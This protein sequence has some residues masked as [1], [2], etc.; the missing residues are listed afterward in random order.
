VL[1]TD[2]A[3]IGAGPSGSACAGLLAER[4][5]DVTLIDQHVFPRDKACGDGLLPATTQTLRRIGLA[6]LL[7]EGL[8][9]NGSRLIVGH[10][11]ERLKRFT[12]VRAA[13]IRRTSLDKALLDHAIA[14]GVTFIKA[15]ALGLDATGSSVRLTNGDNADLIGARRIVA[16]DGPTSVMRRSAGLGTP[17]YAVRAWALRGYFSTERPLDGLF[18]IYLPLEV[19]GMA[20][21]G[22]G[23]LF[24]VDLHVANVGVVFL[25][26]RGAARMP[27]LSEALDAFV[28]ELRL[29]ASHRYGDIESCGRRA[30]SP[31]GMNFNSARC[32]AGD[33]LL[34]GDAAGVTN[35]L[36]GEGIGPALESAISGARWIER[37][38]KGEAKLLGHGRELGRLMPGAGQ[39][40]SCVGRL[41][42][43]RSLT[44]AERAS[45]S[46][47][48]LFLRSVARMALE[49]KRPDPHRTEV[50]TSLRGVDVSIDNMLASCGDAVLDAIR[51]PFPF[52]TQMLA[53]HWHAMG[54][55]VASATFACALRPTSS[56]AADPVS[57][58]AVAFEC[59]APLA[60][61]IG[62]LGDGVT[63]SLAKLNNAF[64]ILTA[65]FA[66]S[67]ALDAA[68]RV[69]P[70]VTVRFFQ[71]VRDICQ[72]GAIDAADR[73]D[74]DRP[75]RRVIMA[76][77]LKTGAV[78][79]FAAALGAEI[80]DQ[81]S[82]SVE[83]LS[84]F[85]RHLGVA[86][87][88]AETVA[89]LAAIKET[90]RDVAAAIGQGIYSLP[91][92]YAIREDAALRKSL[93]CGA[94]PNEIV[95]LV[96]RLRDTGSIE[97]VRALI[98][99]RVDAALAA[100]APLDDLPGANLL[101][102]TD[103]VASRA[104]YP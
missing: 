89:E 91:F 25:R 17:G 23:W 87:S 62:C 3:V 92:L 52:T 54:G 56:F 16:S 5:F 74:L 53:R 43:A 69:R 26:P 24:P 35:P 85:G 55:P 60:S 75:E 88:L 101:A 28:D 6:P 86:H 49:Y 45:G 58:A 34:I 36:T 4:G 1:D 73:Y 67:R 80:A 96:S 100:I 90:R 11:Q 84:R 46:Q 76:M 22:Y 42:L 97:I 71:T 48:D 50:A 9:I 8:E 70:T 98:C 65:D 15:K 37:S 12:S 18:D 39:D 30:G 79:A 63:G 14:Q 51:T 44:R 83:R 20:V 13:C 32:D 81:P 47:D 72:G 102:L 31:L 99:R 10:R 94:A 66:F 68:R 21:V 38:L 19:A 59:L 2:I 7:D 78:F 77:E 95:D 64:A 61:L 57:S 103:W 40:L 29:R 104:Q 82:A 33:L 93:N 41:A 27:R